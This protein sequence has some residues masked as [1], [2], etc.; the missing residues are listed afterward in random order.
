M[1]KNRFDHFVKAL[2]EYEGVEEIFLLNN[3][4]EIVFKSSD[5][6]L[7]NEEAKEI[8]FAWKEKFYYRCFELD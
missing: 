5:F 8:L 4:G 6:S 7:T 2:N 1:N 3:N